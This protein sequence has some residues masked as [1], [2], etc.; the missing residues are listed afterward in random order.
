MPKNLV[1]CCDGTANTPAR[2]HTNVLKLWLSLDRDEHQIAY[3][4]PG[5]GTMG[6]PSALT[7]IRKRLGQ[8]Y[9]AATGRGL[10]QNV[11]QAY[12]FLMNFYEEGDQIYLFGFSRGAYTVRAL[13]GMID[14][15]GLATP[16]SSNFIPYI[17]SMYSNEGREANRF[18]KRLGTAQELKSLYR[19]PR[20]K[21]IGVWDTV[22]SWG[23]F[24]NFKSLPGT[25]TMPTVD[26]IR[27][28]IALDERRAAFR[29]NAFRYGKQGEPPPPDDDDERLIEMGFS[30][31]HA[32]VGG[33]YQE[34]QSGLAKIALAW[35]FDK[36]EAKGLRVR[37]DVKS[38]L[39][40]QENTI[41]DQAYAKP[42]PHAKAHKSLKG[43]W[44]IL[45]LLP[46]RVWKSKKKGYGLRINFG[47]PRFFKENALLM[48]PSVDERAKKA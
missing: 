21:F 40:G 23:L 10:R 37:A 7:R 5:V 29:Q 41:N 24:F 19:R 20:V 4:D 3:Y 30:G 34:S 33:G 42:D 43:I 25:R 26:F 6:N 13:A 31:V 48:H 36:S 8:A 46:R 32:D 45:E 47:K 28:A 15:Y 2:N 27:H 12:E 1:I 18:D 16:G 39:L 35:M 9:D 44:W 38:A 14:M 22:S 11:I 17:W